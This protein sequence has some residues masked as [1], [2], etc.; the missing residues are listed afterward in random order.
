MD[1]APLHVNDF[2]VDEAQEFDEDLRLAEKAAPFFC[3]FVVSCML[4]FIFEA[5]EPD[6]RR[7]WY[8]TMMW[9]PG[10]SIME[11][12]KREYMD[13]HPNIRARSVACPSVSSD[14]SERTIICRAGRLRPH[15][16][17][18]HARKPLCLHGGKLP[19]FARPLP[20]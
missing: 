17:G 3:K 15:S 1:A 14:N 8:H 4:H 16:E 11:R 18:F 10:K 2:Q 7:D 20:A 6:M 5:E 19:Y 12:R 9:Y 13:A